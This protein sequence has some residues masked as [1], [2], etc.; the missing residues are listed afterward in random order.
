M[1]REGRREGKRGGVQTAWK[2]VAGCPETEVS[3]GEE[4]GT[5]FGGNSEWCGDGSR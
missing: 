4:V 1:E 3:L 5:E 2:M